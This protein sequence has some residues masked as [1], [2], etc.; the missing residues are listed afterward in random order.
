MIELDVRSIP[1]IN[2]GRAFDRYAR[3]SCIDEKKADPIPVI[4]VTVGD[5]A[6][7][8]DDENAFTELVEYLRVA[9][10]LAY[11]EL[12]EFRAPSEDSLPDDTDTLH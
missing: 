12:V 6:T 5:D 8:D 3:G 2:H 11:E 7:E 9:V 10:Q 1:T 4:V